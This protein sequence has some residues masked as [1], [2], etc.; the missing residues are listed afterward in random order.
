MSKALRRLAAKALN[1]IETTTLGLNLGDIIQQVQTKSHAL[2]FHHFLMDPTAPV[3]DNNALIEMRNPPSVTENI[4]GDDVFLPPNDTIPGPLRLDVIAKHAS[5]IEKRFAIIKYR[6]A[7]HGEECF[8]AF[9]DE[10]GVYC[11]CYELCCQYFRDNI[12]STKHST[13]DVMIWASMGAGV[14]TVC[15]LEEMKWKGDRHGWIDG[16]ESYEKHP[17]S[18][19]FPHFPLMKC[20]AGLLSPT[21]I[22]FVLMHALTEDNRIIYEMSTDF[23]KNMY[24]DS[25]KAFDE[26]CYGSKLPKAV[27]IM[28]QFYQQE[29]LQYSYP[30]KYCP[31]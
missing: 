9:F 11:G 4:E 29:L 23:F 1:E 3:V 16:E 26:E 31:E 24:A 30:P 8:L 5:D 6:R 25:Q 10:N 7:Y 12:P 28:K 20:F 22:F 14:K 2:N 18:L 15:D 17:G 27:Q 19:T 13:P 21:E